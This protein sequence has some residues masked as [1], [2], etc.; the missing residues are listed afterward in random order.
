M[1]FYALASHRRAAYKFYVDSTQ[2]TKKPKKNDK[3]DTR[4]FE[5][6]RAFST[7]NEIIVIKLQNTSITNL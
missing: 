1:L 4:K 3:N 2:K 6:F 7:I 5:H